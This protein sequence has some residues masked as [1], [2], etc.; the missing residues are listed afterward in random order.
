MQS[1]PRVNFQLSSSR[2]PLTGPQGNSLIVHVVVNVEHWPFDQ[3]MP[4]ALFQKPHGASR[5]PDVANFCWVEYGLRSGMPRLM[6]ALKARGMPVTAS[7]NASVID[8]Y[9]DLAQQMLE[10]D[11][12]FMGH[13]IVQRSLENEPDEVAVIRESLERLT[14]FSGRRPISWLGPGLGET[15]DTPDHLAAAGIRYIYEWCLDDLPARM[16]TREGVVYAMPYALELNDVTIFAIE[17]HASPVFFERFRDT[18][19]VFDQEMH[20][21]PRVLTI[22]LHPHIIAQPHRLP[23]LCRT[24]DMLQQRSDTVFMN[25]DEIGD[26]YHAAMTGQGTTA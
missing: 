15:T 5:G 23:Y 19:E 14:R 11:W 1:N 26:W 7:M 20:T 8:V 4:R 12:R 3:P 2:A 24:L 22:A 21:Q 13:G 10:A 9:P 16:N 25:C 18:V 6:S 17:K